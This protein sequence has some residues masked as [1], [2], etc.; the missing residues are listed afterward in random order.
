[1]APITPVQ[2]RPDICFIIPNHILKSIADHPDVSEH[3][4]GS[5][6]RSLEHNVR[7]HSNRQNTSNPTANAEGFVPLKVH[8]DVSEQ[9]EGKKQRLEKQKHV[10]KYMRDEREGVEPL[11]EQEEKE[12]IKKGLDRVLYDCKSSDTLP[13][14]A[15]GKEGDDKELEGQGENVW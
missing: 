8:K 9:D 2:I 6:K 10:D 7:L 15:L 3:S 12:A 11:T 14:S 5:A 1:M 4:K 13:G